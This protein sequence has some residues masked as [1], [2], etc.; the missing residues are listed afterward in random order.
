MA[1]GDLHRLLID[2]PGVDEKLG[3]KTLVHICGHYLGSRILAQP[4]TH[5]SGYKDSKHRAWC[6]VCERLV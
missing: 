3:A 2:S 4:R 1:G 5:A 6:L